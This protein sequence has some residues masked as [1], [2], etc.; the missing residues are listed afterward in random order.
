MVI[1]NDLAAVQMMRKFRFRGFFGDPTR[2][3]LLNI[4]GLDDAR[5]PIIAIDD[6]AA[7]IKLVAYARKTHPDLHIIARARDRV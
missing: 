1:D 4:A 3:D 7:T 2:P 5:I 6:R